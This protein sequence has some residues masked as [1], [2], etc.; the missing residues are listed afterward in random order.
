MLF[1]LWISSR[2]WIDLI[3]S[4]L[5]L[6]KCINLLGQRIDKSS[7]SALNAYLIGIVDS[8][9]SS[10]HDAF[11]SVSKDL[12]LSVVVSWYT[13][14]G[15]RRREPV[16][17]MHWQH[18]NVQKIVIRSDKSTHF[19]FES[20]VPSPLQFLIF[21][22]ISVTFKKSFKLRLFYSIFPIPFLSLPIK[23]HFLNF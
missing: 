9:R 22:A 14:C 3:L 20:S 16:F 5:L 1:L 12:Y 11:K 21:R 6:L 17:F 4:N 23:L 15:E 18:G 13:A 10:R 7:E 2:F 19:L 8:C